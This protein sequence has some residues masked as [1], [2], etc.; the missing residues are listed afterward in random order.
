MLNK[1]KYHLQ[2]EYAE[3]LQIGHRSHFHTVQG[4]LFAVDWSG[5]LMDIDHCTKH[6]DLSD[7]SRCVN[8]CIGWVAESMCK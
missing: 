8:I 7:S 4:N 5:V 2:W 1:I 6:F 3:L